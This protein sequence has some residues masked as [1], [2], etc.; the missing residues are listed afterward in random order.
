MRAVTRPAGVVATA[1]ASVPRNAIAAQSSMQRFGPYR[2]SAMPSGICAAAKEKKNALD[3]SPISAALMPIS[4]A[5]SGAMTPTE[6]RRNWL[7]R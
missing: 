3:K 4:R 1:K 6:L 2:S 5:R 7:T